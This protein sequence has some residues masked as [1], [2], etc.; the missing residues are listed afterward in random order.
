MIAFST[1]Q[2]GFFND[3]ADVVR[4]FFGMEK[5]SQALEG[6]GLVLSHAFSEEGGRWVERCEI[7]GGGKPKASK[8]LSTDPVVSEDKL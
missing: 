6:D 4:L 1:N 5:I 8:T 2:S 7:S 3:M